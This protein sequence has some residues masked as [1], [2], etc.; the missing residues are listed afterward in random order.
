MKRQLARIG[1]LVAVTALAALAIPTAAAFAATSG[2]GASGGG[3]SGGGGNPAPTSTVCPTIT[4]DPATGGSGTCNGVTVTIP[5]QQGGS[6]T[7]IIA[8]ITVNPAGAIAVPNPPAGFSQVYAV[9]VAFTCSNTGA[10]FTGTFSPPASV[11]VTNPNIAP[12]RPIFEFLDG[13][14]S[15]VTNATVTA[16]SATFSIPMDPQFVFYAPPISGGTLAVTGKPVVGEGIL[17]GGLFALGV[18]GVW[19]VTRRRTPIRA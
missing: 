3:G 1:G 12:G 11:V 6:C 5:P 14:W 8:T 16:G 19:R 10:K 15:Q 13:A 17:A 7:N 4:V 2:P 9:T 18:L